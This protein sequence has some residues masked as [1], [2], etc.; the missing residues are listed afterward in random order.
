LVKQLVLLKSPAQFLRESEAGAGPGFTRSLGFFSLVMLGLG[1]VVG[2][3]IFSVP[4][5]AAA[6][7]AGPG[8]VYSFLIAGAL[9]A[10][11]GLCYA[12]LA[13]L[14][15]GAGSAYAYT[16]ASLGELP[17]WMVGWSLCLE[18][19][20]GAVLVSVAW[21]GYLGSLL[22]DTLGL[23]L[24]DGL[25]LLTCGP[26][27]TVR[28]SGGETARGLWNLPATLLPGALT[29]LLARGL[30]GGARL[31]NAIVAT[32][33]L[34]IL[35]FVALGI[36]LVSREFLAADPAASGPLALVPPPEIVEGARRYGWGAGGVLTAVGVVFLAYIGFDAVS[37]AGLEA[38]NPRRD[39]PRSILATIAVSTLLYVL[40]ALVLTGTVPWRDLGREPL[41][42][43]IDRIIGLRGWGPG[44]ALSLALFVKAGALAGLTSGVLVTLMAQARILFAMGRDGLLPG[45]GA[46]DAR[47]GGP[48]A[49]TLLTGALVALAAGVLPLALLSELVSI[50]TLL[51]FAVV[52]AAVPI[53]RRTRPLAERPFRIP[54]PG[55]LGPLGALTALALMAHLPLGTWIRLGVWLYLGLAVYFVYG[56]R[57]S[58]IQA[59]SGVAFGSPWSD[60]CSLVVHASAV[61]ALAWGF[62][63]GWHP[64]MLVF[65]GG[66]GFWSGLALVSNGTEGSAV[67][68]A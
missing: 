23:A 15:P 38:R 39:V 19:G 67:N 44:A 29:V 48:R 12:E 64:L 68:R 63:Q 25:R 42:Q 61:A 24:P 26:L 3:G 59:A 10:V 43:G 14:V 37:T 45:L 40:V 21:S 31:N 28:L 9:C 66:L 35:V 30:R 22:Q 2:A 16:Y 57:H 60:A 58:R 50:G 56:R 8:I 18:Y 7:Y 46:V 13:G 4:G 41:A 34:I 33:L 51:A 47:M 55:L 11:A 62:H 17:A 20:L 65:E 27:D 6:R 5:L 1:L 32:K 49:A 52:C 54:A 36:G 53:L